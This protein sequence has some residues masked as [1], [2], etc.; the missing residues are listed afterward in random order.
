M[1]LMRFLRRWRG[2]TLIELLV[3]IAIIAILI[4][5]LVPAVQKVREAAARIQCTNNLKQITLATM[6]CA[7]QH[8]GQLPPGLGNYPVI[9]PSDRNGQGGLLFHILPY[10]EQDTMYKR[11]LGTDG[12]NG[13]LATYSAWNVQNI[14]KVKTYICPSDPTQD[15]ASAV[16]GTIWCTAVTSY[17]YNGQVFFVAYPWGWGN[18]LKKFPS[19]ITDGTSQTVAYTEKE[20]IS[21][22]AP[23]WSPD[24][25]PPQLN[26]WVDWG[27]C[28]ASPESGDQ[29][30]GKT[31][32]QFIF[33]IQPRPGFGNGNYP[34]SPHPGGINVALFDG[35]VRF[36]G[37]GVSGVTFF[38]AMTPQ[39]QEVLGSDWN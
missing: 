38:N 13:N 6:N 8:A 1:P 3:V 5:L 17:A 30:Q 33:Q 11:S 37:A 28:V 15:G 21:S 16:N 22:G 23:N 31:P 12:R 36:L 25:W 7:D 14:G 2:F 20:M 4:G 39:G 27:P 32:A 19:Y 9:G 26:V 24:N 34:N 35:S 10:V 29:M 18:G